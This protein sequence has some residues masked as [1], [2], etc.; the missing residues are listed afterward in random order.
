MVTEPI[1]S[2]ATKPVEL[3]AVDP[4]TGLANTSPW[5]LL[6]PLAVMVK[7][8]GVILKATQLFVAKVE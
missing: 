3:N 7:G 6:T 4:T 8:A 5:Y 1:D 2:G